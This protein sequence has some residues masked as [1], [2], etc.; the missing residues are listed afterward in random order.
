MKK[1]ITWMISV[2]A[3]FILAGCNM[4]EKGEQQRKQEESM[5]PKPEK[6]YSVKIKSVKETG[7]DWVISGT[8][9][10]PDKSEII[11]IDPDDTYL[12]NDYADDIDSNGV[13]P[14]VKHGKFTVSVAST[15]IMGSNNM[16]V[17]KTARVNLV[18][19]STYNKDHTDSVPTKLFHKILKYSKT[20][21]LSLSQ[22]MYD[23]HFGIG[24]DEDQS[25]NGDDLTD[26]DNAVASSEAPNT[27]TSENVDPASFN[28]YF[29]KYVGKDVT[30]SGTVLKIENGDDTDKIIT[31]TDENYNNAVAIRVSIDV[32]D[33]LGDVT[34]QEGDTI[35]VD[36]AAI[37]GYSSVSI[38]GS[39]KDRPGADA[40]DI[41]I[42]S[43]Y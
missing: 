23:Y 31:L 25:S 17:N 41:K 10:A 2:M 43:S 20:T 36:G 27:P 37:P 12:R 3:V 32:M 7:S 30:I 15:S 35:T 24:E 26:E 34:L 8:T 42:T 40:T 6:L 11:G 29:K 9:N 19:L 13:G 1:A 18:A 22:A 38:S 33:T 21:K 5:A 4:V 14:L 16:E 28:R 39:E